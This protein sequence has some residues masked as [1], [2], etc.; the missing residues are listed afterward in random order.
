MHIIYL[1]HLE[2][3]FL[4]EAQ[5][6]T[7]LKSQF[8]QA[9]VTSNFVGNDI[10]QCTFMLVKWFCCVQIYLNLHVTATNKWAAVSWFRFDIYVQSE[11]SKNQVSKGM[12]KTTPHSWQI[13][14]TQWAFT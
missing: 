11:S 8:R 14:I 3:A 7:K 1:I 10:S 12:L 13:Y 5:W 6:I 2:S 4:T 9:A